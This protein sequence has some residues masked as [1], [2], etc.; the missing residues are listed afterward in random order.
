MEFEEL[1]LG[2]GIVFLAVFIQSASGFGLALV[3][4]AILAGLFG[5]Q[6]ATPLVAV[7]G[8]TLEIILL[9]I[10]HMH[11]N[12][13]AVWKITL[14]SL[15]GIPFG[16]LWL[17]QV[18][19]EIVIFILGVLIVGYAIYAL[20]GINLPEIRHTGWDYLFGWIAG[21]LGGAYNAPGP[22]II[23][24]GNSQNW[25]PTEFKGNLQGFFVINSFFVVL[26]HLISRNYNRQVWLLY[27][28][29]LPGLILGIWLGTRLDRYMNPK[30][31]HKIVLLM[32]L[33]MGA[34]MI[35]SEFS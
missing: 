19:E 5:I 22:P 14:A 26:A 4:M 11:L 34:R 15:A 31:F 16:I 6:V 30:R 9:V 24:Y 20:S 27:L 18:N 28:G 10:Y 2:L 32:L 35:I 17:R 23:L 29:S 3:S 8:L 33:V 12:I 7:I 13:R 1:F 21:M 25:K